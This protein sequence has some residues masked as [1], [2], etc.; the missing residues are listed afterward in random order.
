MDS[1]YVLV[2]T[3]KQ[4]VNESRFACPHFSCDR[5]KS[6]SILDPV[7]HGVQSF[8]VAGSKVEK[9]GVVVYFKRF[10]R[11]AVKFIKH[12]CYHVFQIDSFFRQREGNPFGLKQSNKASM[13]NC[14]YSYLHTIKTSDG[15]QVGFILRRKKRGG[16][17]LLDWISR[18]IRE[19]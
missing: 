17:T 2:Q 9:S 7:D 19:H 15:C 11:K 5:D 18:I 10:F 16:I 14:K 4:R 13:L 12:I 8:S 1:L 3:F 6:P